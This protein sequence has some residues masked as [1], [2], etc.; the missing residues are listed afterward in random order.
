MID[1]FMLNANVRNGSQRYFGLAVER[2]ADLRVS[3]SHHHRWYCVPE[4]PAVAID[5]Y[6]TLLFQV[7]LQPHAVWWGISF[8]AVSG[9]VADFML[10]ISDG[11]TRK[12]YFSRPVAAAMF[13]SSNATRFR[14]VLLAGPTV[15]ESGH[16]N[17][18]ITNVSAA[19]I[20]PQVLL[21][22]SEPE[23]V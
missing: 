11:K 8:S 10:Q 15:V 7:R 2:L 5:A 16:L 1:G 4:D 13:A 19:A 6:D 20:S 14:P 3:K 17:V 9:S 23:V 12:P 18:A 22:V 21:W